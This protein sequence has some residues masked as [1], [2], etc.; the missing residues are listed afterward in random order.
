[1][2]HICVRSGF[3][4][5]TQS[6]SRTFTRMHVQQVGVCVTSVTLVTVQ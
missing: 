6:D 1:M 4:L 2:L 5:V 3:T